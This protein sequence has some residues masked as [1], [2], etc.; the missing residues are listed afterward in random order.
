MEAKKEPGLRERKKKAVRHAIEKAALELTLEHGYDEVS[1]EMICQ[2]AGVSQRTFYNYAGTK[3]GAV[4]GRGIPVQDKSLQE[5][6]IE[7]F[8]GTVFEDMLTLFKNAHASLSEEEIDL[9]EKRAE[10]LRQNPE[11]AKRGFSRFQQVGSVTISLVSARLEREKGTL[12]NPEEEEMTK[13][14]IRMTMSL[15]IALIHYSHTERALSA[16]RQDWPTLI[17]EAFRLAKAE[18]GCGNSEAI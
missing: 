4:L 16:K 17:D 10:V 18:L 14:R 1:V 12:L 7:G 5:A 9:L 11:L 3:E 13:K 8:G 6:Y 2:V 15:V